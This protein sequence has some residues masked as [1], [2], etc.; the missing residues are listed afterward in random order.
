M[1]ETV[2]SPADIQAT[3]DATAKS[4]IGHVLTRPE[5]DNVLGIL[6]SASGAKASADAAAATAQQQSDVSTS[7][8]VYGT[9]GTTPTGATAPGAG[10]GPYTPAQ[11]AA[12]VARQGGSTMQQQVAAALVTGIESDGTLNDQNP[13]STASGLFQFLDT[14]WQGS[15]PAGSPGHAGNA[16]FQQQVAAFIKNS[17]G[18]NF[19]AWSPDLGGD[20]GSSNGDS[21]T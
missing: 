18:D 17:A 15:A 3:A 6:N 14:T 7:Q 9:G 10:N 12:E 5:V 2:S 21:N 8:A 19:R 4:L 13:T 20:Y 16:T 11:V 1:E